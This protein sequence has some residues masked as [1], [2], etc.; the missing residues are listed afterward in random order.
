MGI[1]EQPIV[2]ISL[3]EADYVVATS[4]SFQAVWLRRLMNDL[5]HMENEPTPIFCNNNSTI[6]LSNNHV[7]HKKIKH[8][9]IHFHFIR[10][11]VDNGDISLQ[12]YGSR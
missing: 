7:L 6:P 1:Q 10:E 9:D 5:A 11:F 4:T 3:A 8:I 2:A 12:F